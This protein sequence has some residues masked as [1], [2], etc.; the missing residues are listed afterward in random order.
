[1]T[2]LASRAGNGGGDMAGSLRKRGRY[3]WQLPVYRVHVVLHRA[4]AQAMRW[5]WIWLNPAST[6]SP[7][8][9]PPPELCPPSPEQVAAL[10]ESVRERT[11]A[12]YT[13]LRLAVSTG[14][15]RSQLLAL[16]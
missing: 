1:M 8:R 9:V 15:R 11:P 7:P 3:S 5:E 4:L 2:A 16:R 6:A 13:Y 10:L 14:A 12:L